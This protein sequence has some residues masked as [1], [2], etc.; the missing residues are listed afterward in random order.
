[1]KKIILVL[2]CLVFLTGCFTRRTFEKSTD[3][4]QKSLDAI[5][6]DWI[7]ALKNKAVESGEVFLLGQRAVKVKQTDKKIIYNVVNNK[8]DYDQEFKFDFSECKSLSSDDC[9][10][11]KLNYLETQNIAAKDTAVQSIEL[12][13]TNQEKGI[14][15]FKLKVFDSNNNEF[16]EYLDVEVEE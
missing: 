3:N 2:L 10:N 11:I 13:T 5:E 12:V 4:L 6:E 14:F 9:D 1:M 8:E 15:R 7:N 16:F